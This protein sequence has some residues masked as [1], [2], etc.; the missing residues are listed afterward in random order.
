MG[1]M[2]A[3]VPERQQNFGE[4]PSYL[5]SYAFYERTLYASNIYLHFFSI[6]VISDIRFG[7]TPESHFLLLSKLLLFLKD[8]LKKLTIET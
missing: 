4:M 5:Y 6:M 3:F 1:N 7:I 2:F 8:F